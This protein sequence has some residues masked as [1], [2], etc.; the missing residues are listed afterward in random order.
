MKN[1]ILIS[2][3]DRNSYKFLGRSSLNMSDPTRVSII[4]PNFHIK[5]IAF[6]S[7]FE[8]YSHALIKKS[9]MLV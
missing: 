2:T 7:R 1:T 4:I 3:M 9:N 6:C 8:L 5:M